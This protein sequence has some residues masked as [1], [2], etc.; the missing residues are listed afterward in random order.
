MRQ[1][2]IG[3]CRYVISLQPTR[4]EPLEREGLNEG[5]MKRQ[6]EKRGT[7]GKKEGQMARKSGGG[8][9]RR[10]REERKIKRQKEGRKIF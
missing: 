7:E 5:W 4:P 6:K 9:A 1:K 3:K 10:G 8:K 2:H